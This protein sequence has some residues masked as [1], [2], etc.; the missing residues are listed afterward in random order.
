MKTIRH[1]NTTTHS[2]YKFPQCHPVPAWILT[3][4]ARYPNIIEAIQSLNNEEGQAYKVGH[5][6]LQDIGTWSCESGG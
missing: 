1:D 6:T 3:F 4:L 5:G 2:P